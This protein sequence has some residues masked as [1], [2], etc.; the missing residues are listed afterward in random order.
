MSRLLSHRI[1]RAHAG[2]ARIA[3]ARVRRAAA[4]GG[5]ARS[6][7]RARQNGVHTERWCRGWAGSARRAF[8]GGPRVAR[9]TRLA[10]Q[11]EP[12]AGHNSGRCSASCRW[13][14]WYRGIGCR[15]PFANHSESTR[16]LPS[17][18]HRTGSCMTLLCTRLYLHFNKCVK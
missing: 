9:R 2:G 13:C 6:G 17:T 10:E 12:F 8:R 5:A 16:S 7:P 4:T 15:L 3:R 1:P 11:S 18:R 14:W